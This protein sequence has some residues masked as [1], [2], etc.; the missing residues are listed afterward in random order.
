M[1][2]HVRIVR[3]LA[4]VASAGVMA[5]AIGG[6]PAAHAD[7]VSSPCQLP[8]TDAVAQLCADQ[9]QFLYGVFATFIYP[10]VTYGSPPEGPAGY[11]DLYNETQMYTNTDLSASIAFG[12]D[13]HYIGSETEYQPYWVDYTNDPGNFHPIGNFARSS[14]KLNHTFMAIPHCSG[15]KNWDIF[16]DFELVGTTG[17][18]PDASSQ[19]VR[20]GWDLAGIYGP[21][22]LSTTQ[23][24]VMFLDGN[25]Q[26]QRFDQAVTSTRAPDGNCS[27]GANSDYCWHFDT[28]I[29]TVTN[30]SSQYVVSWDVTKQIIIP[31]PGSTPAAPGSLTA[32]PRVGSHAAGSDDVRARAQQ[33]V[34][35][36]LGHG[37][38][39]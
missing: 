4:A 15:C 14:D 10:D 1:G 17:D 34:D 22:G 31:P 36:R 32:G 9:D 3:R 33:L 24:R 37:H 26:F 6:L 39:R 20:T 2:V 35:A 30:G 27:P 21:V 11:N 19:H 12:L 25:Y 13:M 23:N 5:V 8:P 18:Q 29:N 38:N 16:Y 28:N 7:D